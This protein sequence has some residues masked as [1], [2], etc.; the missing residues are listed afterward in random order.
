[1]LSRVLRHRVPVDAAG[2]GFGGLHPG[3]E[4]PVVATASVETFGICCR[5]GPGNLWGDFVEQQRAT[6]AEIARA[7]GVSP[8]ARRL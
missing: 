7:A 3:A 1:M 6:L 8:A 5:P 2:G 4:K